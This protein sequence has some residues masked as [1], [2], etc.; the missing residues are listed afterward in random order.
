MIFPAR[1]ADHE[2]ARLAAEKMTANGRSDGL[3]RM[4]AFS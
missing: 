1:R 4:S 3:A 2:K